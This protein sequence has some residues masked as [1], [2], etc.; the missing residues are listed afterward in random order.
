MGMRPDVLVDRKFRKRVHE[1]PE[2]ILPVSAP[3]AVPEFEL[4]DGAPAGLA[5]SKGCRHPIPH[6]RIAIRPEHVDPA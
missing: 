2:D 3:C 6:G 1:L 4:H 5:G